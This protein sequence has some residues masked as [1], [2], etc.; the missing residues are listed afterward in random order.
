M[1]GKV[2]NFAGKQSAVRDCVLSPQVSCGTLADAVLVFL[3]VSF[4]GEG[5][6][7]GGNTRVTYPDE[8]QGMPCL[9]TVR[10]NRLARFISIRS[11][12]PYIQRYAILI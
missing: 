8:R 3:P 1:G 12:R 11:I 9:Y 10:P 7:T 6:Y 4:G 5:K 2:K